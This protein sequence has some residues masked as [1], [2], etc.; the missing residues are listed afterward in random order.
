MIPMEP[1]A[2][3]TDPGTADISLIASDEEVI[4]H[5]PGF[6]VLRA[7]Y[8]A[9]GYY[10][11]AADGD[12][13]EEDLY[14][15]EVLD[16]ESTAQA[17]EALDG[18]AAGKLADLGLSDPTLR[19]LFPAARWEASDPGSGL[20]ERYLLA[21][22]AALVGAPGSVERQQALEGSAGWSAAV[23]EDRFQALPDGW[24][25]RIIQRA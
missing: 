16:A 23:I 1:S 3:R 8:E 2:W 20:V 5:V 14:P 19:R 22:A 25:R 4:L 17:E 9:E 10:D 24:R 21:L 6:A 15:I 7:A 18:E 12:P 13:A 11:E